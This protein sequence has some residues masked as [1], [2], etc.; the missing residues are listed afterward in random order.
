MLI[1][2]VFVDKFM[3]LFS[4]ETVYESRADDKSTASTILKGG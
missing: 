2:R 1:L 4:S 3:E